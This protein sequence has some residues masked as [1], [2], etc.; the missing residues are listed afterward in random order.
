[1]TKDQERTAWITLKRGAIE[2][3]RGNGAAAER[4]SL[5]SLQ[6]YTELKDSMSAEVAT[7][8]LQAARCRM[9]RG[10]NGA[11]RLA[12]RGLEIRRARLSP[13]HPDIAQAEIEVARTLMSYGRVADAEPLL[14]HATQFVR[15]PPFPLPPWQV[16]EAES[17]L[18]WCAGLLGRK[19][20]AVSLLK[21]AVPKL[22]SHPRPICRREA[23]RHLQVIQNSRTN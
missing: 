7:A 8:F 11:E 13:D 17:A 22:L 5:Q 3:E 4:L 10:M 20:E 18:G 12:R 19:F 16:G 23:A 15:N 21:S 2:L 14:R 6:M 1:M 9:K